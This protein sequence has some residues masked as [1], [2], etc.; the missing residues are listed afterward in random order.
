MQATD[1]LIEEHR[2]IERVLDMLETTIRRIHD[3]QPVPD[4]FPAWSIEFLRHF[5][6]H[7]HH[8]KEEDILFPL[9]EQRGVPREGGPI[10]VM[11]YEHEVG[12]DCVKRMEQAIAEGEGGLPKYAAAAA[13]FSTL[14]RQHI[15]KENNVLFPM[16]ERC[17]QPED[18][19]EVLRAYKETPCAKNHPEMHGRFL[20]EVDRWEQEFA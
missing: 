11:E 15:H 7:C 12:R 6:D 8:G 20:Q 5:A 19:A 10:G 4:E 9:L 13:E 18:H 3:G 16:A 14:L 2:V 17:L 1:V